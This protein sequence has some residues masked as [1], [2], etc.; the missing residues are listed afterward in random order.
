MIQR[1]LGP[2]AISAN[3]LS[4]IEGIPQSTLSNWLRN[5]GTLEG[6]KKQN[7][8][9]QRIPEDLSLDE[10]L[11]IITEI[12]QLPEDQIGSYIRERGLY[13]SQVKQWRQAIEEAL[14]GSSMR[15]ERSKKNKDAKRI[16]QLE[17]EL[18]RKDKALAETAAILALKKKVE[19]IWGD[20]EDDTV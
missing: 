2:N 10:K 4:R 9:K 20:G 5:A 3:K 13:E 15:K 16:K 19:E 1:M 17:R 8:K 6:M 12:A 11:G 14:S 18:N 7:D